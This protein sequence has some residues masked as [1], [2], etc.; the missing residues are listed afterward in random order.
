MQGRVQYSD[1]RKASGKRWV[2]KTKW[3]VDGQE[4][5]GS[6]SANCCSGP[7]L[8]LGHPLHQYPETIGPRDRR[9]YHCAPRAAGSRGGQARTSESHVYFLFY[10]FFPFYLKQEAPVR[11]PGGPHGAQLRAQQTRAIHLV[12]NVEII[13]CEWLL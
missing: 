1:Y 9:K 10:Y 4:S 6:L 2:R 13:K 7:L 3:V 12:G 11:P 8:P 5:R